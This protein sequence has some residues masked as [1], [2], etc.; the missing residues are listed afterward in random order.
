MKIN[1]LEIPNIVR[2]YTTEFVPAIELARRYDVTRAAIYGV[3]KRAGV[4]TSYSVQAHVQTLCDYEQ[5]G[6]TITKLRSV[7]RKNKHAFCNSG[8]YGAWKRNNKRKEVLDKIK[9]LPEKE[10]INGQLQ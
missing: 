7:I 2:L 5:C 6:Q 1:R 10:I 9:N 4:N 8:C 3:L